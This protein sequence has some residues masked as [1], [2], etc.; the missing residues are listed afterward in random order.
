MRFIIAFFL[1]SN[2]LFGAK[3]LG[4]DVPGS[5]VGEYR[6]VTTATVEQV[7]LSL[8]KKGITNYHETRFDTR[9]TYVVHLKNKDPRGKWEGINIYTADRRVYIYVIPRKK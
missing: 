3:R 1:L 2:I 7:I 6:Y 5:K 8:R 4:V 9:G